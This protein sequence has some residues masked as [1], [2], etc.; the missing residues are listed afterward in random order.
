MNKITYV[1]YQ[2][3]PA[4]TANSIQTMANIKYMIRHG[5]EV[6]LVFPLREKTSTDNSEE[7][8]KFYSIKEDF[9]IVGTKH[10]L[11]F[12][13]INVL[14]RIL[15]LYSHFLWSYLIVNKLVKEKS[16]TELFFTRSDWVFFFLSRKN[17]NVVF[18]CHQFTKL[19]KLLINK[20]LTKDRSKIIFLNNNLKD[21]YEK[22]YILNN[23]YTILHNGVDLEYYSFDSKSKNNE[24]VFIGKLKRF[25]QSR[26][27]DFLLKALTVLDPKYTLKIVG[28]TD[29]EFQDLE[30]ES[31]NL[32]VESR[33][34]IFRRVNYSDV[35]KHLS[36]SSIG[37][38]INSSKNMH[39]LS[40]TSP[41]K[42]FEY[43][44]AGL[45]IIAVDFPSHRSLPFSDNISFFEENNTKSV[46][47]A[48]KKSEHTSKLTED[49]FSDI[50]LETRTKKIID[51]IIS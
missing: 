9:N 30:K 34:K 26:N 25:G 44:A 29:S 2:T 21:D 13:K 43:L 18:E 48:I 4:Q 39:S 23:N 20:S 46:I 27:I 47:D 28:A 49:I 14:N 6:S 11:P 7:L 51:F 32:G 3:F 8:K 24:I 22:K 41:I 36:S 15:F 40:Y 12:G 16:S 17:R 1:T 38:L 42:Y 5:A 50:S 45:K 31:K 37:V 10:N 19:R 35:A 33:V